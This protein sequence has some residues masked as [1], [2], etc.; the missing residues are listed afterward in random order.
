MEHTIDDV[1]CRECGKRLVKLTEF[2][3]CPDGHGKLKT[4]PP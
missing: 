1:F 3:S 2:M 4:P